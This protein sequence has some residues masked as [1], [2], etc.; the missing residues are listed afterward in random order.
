M[1]ILK[2]ALETIPYSARAIEVGLITDNSLLV[3]TIKYEA[4][5][6]RSK[7]DKSV[8]EILELLADRY[9]LGLETVKRYVYKRKEVLIL[10]EIFYS[11]S[12]AYG[13]SETRKLF[14]RE[15]TRDAPNRLANLILNEYTE[16][17]ESSRIDY[18]YSAKAGGS[19]RLIVIDKQVLSKEL[20]SKFINCFAGQNVRRFK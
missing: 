20:S 7:G 19:T 13:F 6:M 1:D 12:E 14:S 4:L 18:V 5:R 3:Y 9:C 11:F 16:I 15:E 10:P 8:K 2:I 17:S